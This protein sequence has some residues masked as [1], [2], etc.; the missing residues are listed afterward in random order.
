MFKREVLKLTQPRHAFT[1]GLTRFH[2]A[3]AV[4]VLWMI[5]PLLDRRWTASAMG[6]A[7]LTIPSCWIFAA[8]TC[9]TLYSCALLFDVG[10]WHFVLPQSQ[11]WQIMLIVR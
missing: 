3:P 11:G 2:C 8:F 9:F 6:T 1:T 10:Q 4:Q 7:G 5:Y